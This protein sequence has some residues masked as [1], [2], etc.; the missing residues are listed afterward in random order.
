MK[1]GLSEETRAAERRTRASAKRI[2]CKNSAHSVTA[3]LE[4]TQ[5]Q[6]VFV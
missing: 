3:E 2:D 1:S 5:R 6:E 4:L